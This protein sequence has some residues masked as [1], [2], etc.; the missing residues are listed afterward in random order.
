VTVFLIALW[1]VGLAG[2]GVVSVAVGND[3]PRIVRAGR[4]GFAV[5]LA[6]ELFAAALIFTVGQ[7]NPNP[8]YNTTRS[9][10]WLFALAGG[11]PVALVSGLAVR[12]GYVGHRL[13]LWS[14][15][16]LTAA[17][18]LA[19][20][21]AFIPADQKLQGLGRFEHGHHALDVVVLL[22]PSLILLGAE[23]FRG[24]E[25]TDEP[26]IPALFRSVPRRTAAGVALVLL[27]VLWFAGASSSGLVLGLGAIILGGGVVLGLRSRAQVRRVRR[28]L[29]R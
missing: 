8:D 5:L 24:S 12:R 25:T 15:V 4:V 7:S 27:F 26:T 13:V 2:A 3:N 19:F 6:V 11:V 18:Y 28:D 20:P 9:M 22:L 14:A 10:W 16:L 23:V 29:E 1:L 21:V 17:L